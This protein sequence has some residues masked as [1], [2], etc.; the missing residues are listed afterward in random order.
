MMYGVYGDVLMMENGSTVGENDVDT[1]GDGIPDE[2][3]DPI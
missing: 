1:D 2:L 3:D